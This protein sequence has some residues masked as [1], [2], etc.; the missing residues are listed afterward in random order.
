MGADKEI[1]VALE[2]GTSA[3]R[4]IAGKKKADGTVQ[5]L[6]IE[7]ERTT[8]AIQRGVIYN[9]DKTTQAITNIVARL[10]DHL[11]VRIGKAYVGVSGQSL[12]T[13]ANYISRGLETKVKITPE[14]VDNLKDNN[15]T[16][17]YTDSQILDVV[18]QEYV[19]GNRSVTDP[20][21]IQTD[22]IEARFLNVVAKNV[23]LDNIHKCMRLANV[24]IADIFISPLA[25]ADVLLSDNEKRSGCAMVDFGAGTTTVA[26]YCGNLLRHLVVI[27]LGGSSITTDIA[28]AHQ[29]DYDEAEALKRKYGI[30]YVAAE[31]D[32]P[33]QLPI[34]NDRTISENDLQNIVGARQEEIILNVWHQIEQMSS[35]LLT[36]IIITGG[37]AQLKDMPEA[38]KHFAQFQKVKVAKSLI[39]TSDVAP[40]VVTPQGSSVDTLIALLSHGEAC[41]IAEGQDTPDQPQPTEESK[42]ADTTASVQ[43]AAQPAEESKPAEEPQPEEEKPTKPKKKLGER[44]STLGRIWSSIFEA[45][46]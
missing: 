17:E 7:Q 13:T 15:L 43:T 28:T 10:S 19:V 3:I 29:M 20:I 27:P 1:I 12:H 11:G 37:A 35:K 2:F 21:G 34:S 16:T 32:K 22:Q 38:I 18:P 8:D 41:C 46:E 39:T 31:S 5:I 42:P 30:A 40:G 45:D 14:L 23:L 9:I 36:G 26:V 44:L 6:D 25:L 4:G 24:D 33:Q